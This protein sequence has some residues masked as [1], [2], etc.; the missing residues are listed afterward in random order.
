M[1]LFKSPS[2]VHGAV[3]ISEITCTPNPYSK[4]A[5]VSTSIS[6]GS[7]DA[8]F[9]L[10][11]SGFCSTVS[12]ALSKCLPPPHSTAL[13]HSCGTHSNPVLSIIFSHSSVDISVIDTIQHPETPNLSQFL[14][15]LVPAHTCFM[16][17]F[18]ATSLYCLFVPFL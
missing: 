9:L 2:G 15:S 14:S 6:P 3:W 1:G 5:P 7:P 11:Y 8:G 13:V 18:I 17:L 12:T 10:P 4:T 16:L